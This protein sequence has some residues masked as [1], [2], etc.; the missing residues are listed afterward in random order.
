MPNHTSRVG[1]CEAW[2]ASVLLLIIH[3]HAP[4]KSKVN[5]HAHTKRHTWPLHTH[6][7]E[8]D[9]KGEGSRTKEGEEVATFCGQRKLSNKASSRLARSIS[10]VAHKLSLRFQGRHTGHTH[11]YTA[12]T[13][14][15]TYR[16]HAH[17]YAHLVSRTS[18]IKRRLFLC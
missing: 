18:V 12:L 14:T 15:H 3:K 16:V 4:V 2:A 10:E 6:R 13:H 1:E 9:G 7:Q 5:T 17:N 11:T 8:R